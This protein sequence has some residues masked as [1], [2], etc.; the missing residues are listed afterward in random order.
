MSLSES[1][2]V[3]QKCQLLEHLPGLCSY[4]FTI[5]R[6]FIMV[7]RKIG[8]DAGTGLF[9]PVAAA[10]ARPKTAIVETIK[11]PPKPPAKKKP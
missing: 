1:L 11:V 2:R 8:R 5:E 10:K 4:M 6:Y 7:T 9:I 3:V